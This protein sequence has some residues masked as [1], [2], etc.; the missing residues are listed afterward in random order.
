MANREQ[1]KNDKSIRV[2]FSRYPLPPGDLLSNYI[3]IWPSR[4][5]W[6]DFGHRSLVKYE[7]KVDRAREP[8]SLTTDAHIGFLSSEKM[9]G[10]DKLEEIVTAA[11]ELVVAAGPEHHFFTM[12]PSME[13]YRAIVKAFGA[14]LAVQIL[15]AARDIVALKGVRGINWWE[16]AIKSDI[17]AMSFLR[18]SEA[19]FAFKNAA[20]ILSGLDQEELGRLSP[21]L[22]AR[23]S[24]SGFENEHE[25]SFKFD[26]SGV[27]PKRMAVVI[28]K[29]GVGKSSTLRHI[30]QAALYGRSGLTETPDGG[31]PIISRLLAFA[32]TNEAESVFPSGGRGKP[33]IWY[34]RFALNRSN[35]AE[36]DEWLSD[37]VIQLARSN[38]TIKDRSRWDIF[39][40]S[41]KAL[42]NS[43]QLALRR[44]EKGA[45]CIHLSQLRLMGEQKSLQSWSDIQTRQDPI[46]VVDGESF[47]LSSGEISFMRFA[48]QVSLYIEN[49]TLLLLDEPE[50]HLHPNFISQ[51]SA[52]L[53]SLLKQ[54]GSAA[55][56]ATHSSYFV[57]EVFRE[58]VSILRKDSG[59][60]VHVEIPRLRTF[61]GDVGAISQHVFGDDG[62]SLLAQEVLDRL[63]SSN[64]SMNSLLE[65]YQD[66]LSIDL[67]GALRARDGRQ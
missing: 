63:V 8:L 51:F 9:N 37:L 40:T 6:N 48:A 58:Q 25:L 50:T 42:S 21:F 41:L 24:L 10:R 36:Q 33:R 49:G 2:L 15:R 59:G 30:A 27:L 44:K 5:T 35:N 53:D 13:S 47:P 38:S 14:K 22:H 26:H 65:E 1:Q 64:R 66:E 54:T 52:L 4:D 12:L 62:P 60:Y 31:R 28:G 57:R 45:Q 16:G 23:F 32:P 34:K 19:Y 29:N 11:N 56:L 43:S 18:N 55:I 3:L 20:P 46:R 17:F 7:I 67:L 39:W 61:G